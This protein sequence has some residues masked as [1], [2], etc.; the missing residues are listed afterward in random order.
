ME[1]YWI[2]PS[3][4]HLGY[5]GSIPLEFKTTSYDGLKEV[6]DILTKIRNSRA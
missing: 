2:L 4:V 5:I 1:S 3:G 6:W